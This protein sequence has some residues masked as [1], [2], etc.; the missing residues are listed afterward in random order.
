MTLTA[1]AGYSRDIMRDISR[2]LLLVNTID[3][4]GPAT[5]THSLSDCD[6]RLDWG[7][8]THLG[9]DVTRRRET[10]GRR[11]TPCSVQKTVCI[12]HPDAVHRFRCVDRG[13]RVGA[14]C[15]RRLSHIPPKTQAAHLAPPRP[16]VSLEARRGTRGAALMVSCR[17]AGRIA[18]FEWTWKRAFRWATMPA[19]SA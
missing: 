13:A 5:H 9:D 18:S 1:R 11:I 15:A 8:R 7:D 19:S 4:I 2:V 10:L 6:S 17:A 3:L 16:T 12:E 14:S